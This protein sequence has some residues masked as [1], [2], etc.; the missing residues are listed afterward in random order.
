MT[1]RVHLDLLQLTLSKV[2]L[3]AG[4]IIL[5]TKV[6]EL[7]Q[8]FYTVNPRLRRLRDEIVITYGDYAICFCKK[9]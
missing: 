8:I 6:L 2:F 4:K 3:N 9:K 1:N 7:S 5:L